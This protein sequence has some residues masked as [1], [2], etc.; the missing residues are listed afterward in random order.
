MV[1]RTV[2]QYDKAGVAALHIEDQVQ[3]KRCGHLMGKQVV[4]VDDF[5]M[6]IRAAVA[7]REAIPGSDIVI[8][9]RTDSAQVL[10]M[11]EAVRRLKLA[12]EAGA[13][14]AFIE[15]VKTKELLESTVKAL[16]PTPVRNPSTR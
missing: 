16:A 7:A 3:T 10:G 8:I 11:E 6:R 5:L 14:A 9:A 2:Y 12:A 13:D 1:A 15:G 4:P